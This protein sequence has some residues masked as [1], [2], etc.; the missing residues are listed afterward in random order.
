MV[1]KLVC[2]KRKVADVGRE[3]HHQCSSA[4][5]SSSRQAANGLMNVPICCTVIFF[6]DCMMTFLH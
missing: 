1:L 4:K 3:Q 5:S 6:N 2:T